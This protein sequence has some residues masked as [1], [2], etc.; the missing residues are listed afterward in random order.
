MV[1]QWEGATPHTRGVGSLAV[2]QTRA[3][4]RV[5]ARERRAGPWRWR[6]DS[7][8]GRACSTEH[9]AAEWIAGVTMGR[10]RPRQNDAL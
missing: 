1:M 2:R 6:A 9:L 10:S 8:N 5:S 4:G 3:R 7:P